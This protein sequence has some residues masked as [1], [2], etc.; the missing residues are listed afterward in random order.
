MYNTPATCG[1]NVTFYAN[2]VTLLRKEYD[3]FKIF[4]SKKSWINSLVLGWE[5]QRN[6]RVKYPSRKFV[7]L[8]DNFGSHEMVEFS[9]INIYLLHNHWIVV[10]SQLSRT[11]MQAG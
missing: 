8:L 10:Y 5:M 7:V 6:L 3:K 4:Y 1:K 11:N 9:N 2:E